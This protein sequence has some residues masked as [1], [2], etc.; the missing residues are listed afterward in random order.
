M[1]EL[2]VC[3]PNVA[4]DTDKKY[5]IFNLGREIYG[6]DVF[7]INN[8]VQMAKITKVPGVSKNYLGIID[9][10]GEIV[11]VMSLQRRMNI[12][13]SPFTDDSYIVVLE[14]GKD[15]LVGV[16]VD[17]VTEVITISDDAMENPT[18]FIKKEDSIVKSVAKRGK[19]LISI[20]DVDNLVE[21]EEELQVS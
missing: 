13:E 3:N 17:D 11:P 12:S 16:V 7:G 4:V 14:I 5:L 15:K 2:A 6:I 18:P 10:R 20:I 9:L 19:D 1:N 21:Q 8:I